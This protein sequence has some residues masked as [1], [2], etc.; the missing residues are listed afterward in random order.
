M[1]MNPEIQSTRNVL[2]VVLTPEEF[3]NQLNNPNSLLNKNF[4]L[5]T[6]VNAETKLINDEHIR[7]IQQLEKLEKLKESYQN[8]LQETEHQEAIQKFWESIEESYQEENE[9]KRKLEDQLNEMLKPVDMERLKD[10]AET[11][12]KLMDCRDKL[13]E[14]QALLSQLPQQ[15]VQEITQSLE[16][17]HLDNVISIK[18]KE[19]QLR[20]DIT[21]P[22]NTARKDL[23]TLTDPEAI[24]KKKEEIAQLEYRD[25]ELTNYIEDTKHLFPDT[26]KDNKDIDVQEHVRSALE[27]EKQSKREKLDEL[28]KEESINVSEQDKFK[29]EL[30]LMQIQMIRQL[31]VEGRGTSIRELTAEAN[32]EI[33][34]I[35]KQFE[36][37]AQALQKQITDS[38]AEI[39]KLDKHLTE[40]SAPKEINLEQPSPEQTNLDRPS[41][42]QGPLTEFDSKIKSLEE[43]LKANKD[44]IKKNQELA[45]SAL[46]END[47]KFHAQQNIIKDKGTREQIFG[48]DFEPASNTAPVISKKENNTY[49]IEWSNT[50]GEKKV[51]NV[52]GEKLKSFAK[53]NILNMNKP[54]EE[55]NSKIEK[56]MKELFD[57]TRDNYKQHKDDGDIV[58]NMNNLIA[59]AKAREALFKASP[60]ASKEYEDE[61]RKKAGLSD[62][63]SKVGD[64]AKNTLLGL[65]G[66]NLTVAEYREKKESTFAAKQ[67]ARKFQDTVLADPAMQNMVEFFKEQGMT[68][69]KAVPGVNGKPPY[70]RF[71]GKDPD[72]EIRITCGANG[73]PRGIATPKDDSANTDFFA[74]SLQKLISEQTKDGK[75][76]PYQVKGDKKP[77]EKF[78]DIVNG[79]HEKYGKNDVYKSLKTIAEDSTVKEKIKEKPKDEKEL[80]KEPEQP[81]MRKS[82]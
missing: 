57:N 10:L 48:S 21:K 73:Q 56:Q 44:M 38:Q 79:E 78:R 42:V 16:K 64:V 34:K 61:I 47:L 70:L 45:N 68:S 40:L 14:Y 65:A 4:A 46:N 49:D 75:A 35:S 59:L 81:T 18:D 41:P 53:D 33:D 3:S 55:N 30:N 82:F 66:L 6:F 31:R 37:K 23:E 20:E 2:E 63:H 13:D 9:E 11:K 17:S 15:Q 32:K 54:Y 51:V 50:Q 8:S 67:E 25:K 60:K 52:D 69:M 80:K 62:R 19:V 22:L 28:L 43:D 7:I 26:T 24:A 76:P 39:D 29:K 5:V 74:M 12:Q 27:K 1:D 72:R 58:V 77:L 36:E 71:K